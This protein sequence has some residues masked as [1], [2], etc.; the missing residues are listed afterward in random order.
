MK[1]NYPNVR[2]F[3]CTLAVPQVLL[4]PLWQRRAPARRGPDVTNRADAVDGD[5]HGSR[6]GRQHLRVYTVRVRV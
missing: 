1:L 5:V 2:P 4:E 3:S 6:H